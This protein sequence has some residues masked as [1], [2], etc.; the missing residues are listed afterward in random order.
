MKQNNRCIKTI[1]FIIV[2]LLLIQM[3]FLGIKQIVFCFIDET[4]Y[5]R[6]M[7]TMISMI[8]VF[9]F[10]L[11]YCLRNKLT[12]SAF[13]TRFG[14]SYIVITVTA[15]IFYTITLF[16][17]NEFSIKSLLMLLYGSI[18]T[19]VFEELLFRGLIWNKI[20][21]CFEKEYETFLIVTILFGL[22]H[23]GYAVGIY[24]WNDGNLLNCIIMKVMMG[25][26][27]GLIT[28]ALRYKTKSCCL[29]IIVHGILNAF[30]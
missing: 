27:F 17:V 21:G 5:T 6:S 16:F 26:V 13:P 11:L 22:W 1:C 4:L 15:V 9:P 3:L 2:W 30:G 18:I 14:A 29:G 19:P 28:G 8:M 25:M 12:M 24:F 10:I 7:T 23:I 20:N